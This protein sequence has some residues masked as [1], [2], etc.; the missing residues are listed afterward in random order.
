[1]IPTNSSYYILTAY[2]TIRFCRICHQQVWYAWYNLYVNIFVLIMYSELAYILYGYW[3]V[4]ETSGKNWNLKVLIDQPFMLIGLITPGPQLVWQDSWVK[5]VC[6][7][8]DSG[9]C[10]INHRD[11]IL[12]SPSP[13]TRCRRREDPQC[14]LHLTTVWT[15]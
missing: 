7:W 9:N 12:D 4:G 10:N 3:F 13:I 15:H 1:M 6:Q 8:V 2:N 14:M 5:Q 11:W